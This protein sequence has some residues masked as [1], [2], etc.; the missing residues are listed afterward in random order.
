MDFVRPEEVVKRF[1]LE[2]GMVAADFGC[3]PGY[4]SVEMAK[5]V[6]K[7]GTVY[8]IDVQKEIL[9]ALKARAEREN[10][11]NIEIIWA[12]L[13]LKNG[14]RLGDQKIDFV[15][16]SNI[17]FQSDSRPAVLE[18]AFRVLKSKGR[19]AVIEWSKESLMGPTRERRLSK[20][21]TERLLLQAGFVYEKDFLADETHYGLL[22]KKP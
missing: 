8:A 12:D 22:F 13:D 18:E 10:L 17:L 15:I 6:G 14:S 1:G 19:V 9:Q 20:E 11:S 3:G 2:P 16:I 7:K 4:Y 5:L 21:E